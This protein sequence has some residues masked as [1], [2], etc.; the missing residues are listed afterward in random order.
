MEEV[1]QAQGPQAGPVPLRLRPVAQALGGVAARYWEVASYAALLVTAAIMRF[2]DLGSRAVHHDESLHAFYAWRLSEGMGYA[3]DPMMHGPF[4]FETTAALFLIF[5]SGDVTARVLSAVAGSVLVA[6]P[7]LFRARL[8]RAASLA[9][10]TMLTFSPAMLYFSRFARNDILTAVWTLGLVV[11]LWRYLDEGRNRYLYA[12]AALLALFFAT[13]ETA[14][15]FTT[16]LGFY[17]AAVIAMRRLAVFRRVARRAGVG[18]LHTV[19]VAAAFLRRGIDLSR[20]SRE[21]AFFL[22]L[23]TLSLPQGAALAGLLQDTALLRWSGLTLARTASAGGPIGAPEGGGLVVAGAIVVALLAVSFRL[24]LLWRWRVWL[25]CAVVFYVI[26][27]LLYSTFFTNLDG[28]GSGWW[29]SLGYWQAQQEVARGHQPFYYYLLLAPLYEFLPMLFSL[30]A[31]VYYLRRRDRLGRFLVFWTV[32]TFLMYTMA[33]EKMPWLLVNLAL[34]MVL[35]A[36]KLMADLWA[37]IEWRR[38]VSGGGILVLPAVPLLL[39]ALW[40]LAFT[41]L[42]SGPASNVL[43]TA[44]LVVIAVSTAGA[45]ALASV[46]WGFRSAAS[47]AAIPLAL[48]LLAITIRV[49]TTAA[50]ANGD[51]PVEMIVYTQSSPDLPRLLDE[52]EGVAATTGEGRDVPITIDGTSGFAWPWAWYLRDH[53]R[54]GYPSY[55][56]QTPDASP[57]AAVVIVHGNN[58]DTF[59]LTVEE[60]YKEEV[61]IRHRWWFPEHTYRDLTVGKVIRSFADRGSWRRAMDYFMHRKLSSGLGS[62]DAYVYIAEDL[63]QTFEADNQ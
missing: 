17:L 21:G 48:V 58:R 14:F 22:M 47:F 20:L 29:R 32:A 49:G 36:A 4:Q 33:A 26:W 56:A 59:N 16:I 5:G 3:H 53:T 35:L 55:T 54:V 52:I 41:G 24:G 27:L 62:E 10:A 8:G 28:I 38:L 18:A 34:P 12:G 42:D 23:F 15:I 50:Y 44:G 31:G 43:E 1:G 2:W 6:M 39:W 11:C 30:A 60:G 51:R 61:R 37:S 57:D 19:R 13:K 45:C 7:W 9:A 40:R 46:R 25:G 63:P